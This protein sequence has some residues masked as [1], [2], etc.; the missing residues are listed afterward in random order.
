[1]KLTVGARGAR[2]RWVG[3]AV[4]VRVGGL[5]WPVRERVM[6]LCFGRASNNGAREG[7]GCRVSSTRATACSHFS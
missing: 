7:L 5:A 2:A 4:R 6:M 1:M 3:A